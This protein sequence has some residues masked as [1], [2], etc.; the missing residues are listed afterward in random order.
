MALIENI[1][2]EDLNPIE[3]AVALQRSAAGIRADPAGGGRGGG[4]IPLNRGQPV[5]PDDPAGGCSAPGGA[6]RPGNGTRPR[7]AR[8][9]RV[10][11]SP[12]P[13][14]NVVGKGLS[15]RQTESLV[16]HNL[17]ARKEKPPGCPAKQ[18]LDPNI[19][20]L[21]DDLVP[22]PGRQGPDPAFTAAK[23][24]VNWCWPTTALDE[25]DGILSSHQV[26]AWGSDP[27]VG[28]GPALWYSGNFN[29]PR[30]F[31]SCSPSGLSSA[32]CPAKRPQAPPI[33]RAAA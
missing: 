24:R 11:T 15:V 4:K 23:A 31:A 28:D 1:Q 9:W 21:Q 8:P 19:R 14:A 12:R 6:R 3:E 22:A 18:T 10:T 32:R 13:R 33:F 16:P 20:H 17:L 2:R 25:L 5:A 30:A 26:M 27:W 7:P 29:A